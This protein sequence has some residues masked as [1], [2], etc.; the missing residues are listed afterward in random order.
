MGC[1][2]HGL[3]GAA[4]FFSLVFSAMGYI[5]MQIVNTE[6]EEAG[7]LA[8]AA[9]QKRLDEV[10]RQDGPAWVKGRLELASGTAP[11]LC[12][13]QPCLWKRTERYESMVEDIRKAGE[14]T[15]RFAFRKVQDD[16]TGAPFEMTDGPAKLRFDDWFGIKPWEDLLQIRH[17]QAPI[18]SS[19]AEAM[20]AS[21]TVAWRVKERFLLA[22]QD[23]WLLAEFKGGKPQ[24]YVNGAVYLT[25][26]GPERFAAALASGGDLSDTMKWVFLIG[27]VVPLLYF[28]SLILKRR[29]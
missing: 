17:D 3:V 1:L 25:G 19:M 18:V 22:G 28:G 15:K 9:V 7:K 24:G 5:G 11:I 13:E 8:A 10:L 27:I 4:C 20:P 21:A 26:L 16:V 12:G 14:W 6:R 29:S 23:V 2:I